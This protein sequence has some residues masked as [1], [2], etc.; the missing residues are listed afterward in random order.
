MAQSRQK[1]SADSLRLHPTKNGSSLAQSYYRRARLAV[2][3]GKLTQ[4]IP[5]YRQT[6]KQD[7]QHLIAHQELGNVF[8]KL[9]QWQQAISC[10]HQALEIDPS[11]SLIHHNLGE[12]YTQLEQRD[13]AVSAYQQ[14]IKL[15]PDSHWS[16][17]NLGDIFLKQEQ[18][19]KAIVA[20]K[21]AIQLNPDFS[22]SHHNLGKA[23]LMLQQ[24]EEAVT[25]CQKAIELNSDSCWSYYNLAE[26][27]L[28]LQKWDE[29]VVAYRQALQLQPDL[30]QATDRLNYALHQRV[31]SKLELAKYHY[32]KAIEQDPDNIELYHKALELQPMSPELY[33]GLGKAWQN[34]GEFQE[35]IA[36]YEKAIVFNPN[37]AEVYGRLAEVLTRVGQETEALEARFKGLTLEPSFATP[38]EHL[39]L[40]DQ[41]RE[42]GKLEQAEICYQRVLKFNPDLIEAYRRLGQLL[43]QSQQWDKAIDWYQQ[44]IKRFP[45]NAECYQGL[46]EVWAKQGEWEKAIEFFEKAIE[47]QPDCWQAYHDCGDALLNLERWQEAVDC[48]QRSIQLNPD[49]VWSYWNLGRVYSK[50]GNWEKVWD[51]CQR[52][53]E[54]DS[55]FLDA[56]LV[57]DGNNISEELKQ[58]I[59]A[60]RRGEKNQQKSLEIEQNGG[61]ILKYNEDNYIEKSLTLNGNNTT[62]KSMDL[63]STEMIATNSSKPGEV[64]VETPET[65]LEQGDAFRKEGK[66]EEARERYQKVIELEPENWLAHHHKGDCL[67]EQQQWEK[68]IEVYQRVITLNPKFCWSYYNLGRALQKLNRLEKAITVIQKAVEVNSD[69]AFGYASWGDILVQQQKWDE[70]ITIYQKALEKNS[71]FLQV[72]EQSADSFFEW[73]KYVILAQKEL[74][75]GEEEEAIKLYKQAVSLNPDKAWVYIKLGD[76]CKKDHQNEAIDNY[77]KAKLIEPNNVWSYINLADIFNRQ[78]RFKE[79]IANYKEGK[80]RAKNEVETKLLQK[81]KDKIDENYNELGIVKQSNRETIFTDKTLNKESESEKLYKKLQGEMLEFH[82]FSPSDLPENL[83]YTAY[84][85]KYLGMTTDNCLSI[86]ERVGV[87]EDLTTKIK[88]IVKSEI[89]WVDYYLAINNTKKKK[90]SDIQI[91]IEYIIYGSLENTHPLFDAYYYIHQIPSLAQET[92]IN[93]LIHFLEIGWNQG[94]SPHPLF[95]TSYYLEQRPDVRKAGINP[96]EHF[97]KFGANER[98]KNPHPLFDILYYLNDNPDINASGMNPLQHFI[99][100]GIKEERNPHPLFNTSYYLQNNPSVKE[101]GKNPINHFMKTGGFDSRDPHPLFSITNYIDYLTLVNQPLASTENPFIN[102]L[103]HSED[104][105]RFACF[106]WKSPNYS[107]LSQEGHYDILVFSHDGSRT[108]APRVLLAFLQQIRESQV[109]NNLKDINIWIV[110]VRDGEL[111]ADFEKCGLTLVLSELDE[112]TKTYNENLQELLESFKR[113]TCNPLVLVNTSA[114]SNVSKVCYE[115]NLPVVSW[116][117]ELPVTIES[118]CGGLDSFQYILLSS[119][120]IIS[121]SDFVASSLVTYSKQED[122]ADKFITIYASPPSLDSKESVQ[123]SE[124]YRNTIRAEFD[125]PDNAFIVMGC[126]TVQERKGCDFFAQVAYQVVKTNKLTDVYFIWVGAKIQPEFSVWLDDDILKADLEENVIFAG[127]RTNPL[128]YMRG[129][130]VFLLT[131]REDPFPLVNMEAMYCKL[132]VI[133]FFGNGGASEVFE[134]NRG[135]AVPYLDTTEMAKAVIRLKNDKQ[136]RQEIGLTAQDCIENKL[137]WQNFVDNFITLIKKDYG[138]QTKKEFK[139]TVVV[140]NYNYEK[141]IFE[142]LETIINQTVKPDE[143]IFLDDKST[144]NSPEIAIKYFDKVNIPNK[145]LINQEN[146]GSPFKQWVKGIREATG[147]LIWIAESDDSCNIDLVRRLKQQFYDPDVVLAYSQSA[148]IGEEGQK[149]DE[150]YLAYTNELDDKKWKIHYRNKGISEIQ[151]A[152]CLK[153]TIP[154]ASAV[155]FRK[156]ALTEECLSHIQKFRFIGDWLLY[157][158]VA[159]AGKVAFVADTLNYHRRHSKTVTAQVEKEDSHAQEVL[160]LKQH[161]LS[162]DF[163]SANA[164]TESLARTIDDFYDLNKRHQLNRNAFVGYQPFEKSIQE[165]RSNFQQRFFKPTSSSLSILIII[166]D[167]NF[168]GGQIAAIRLANELAKKYRVFLCNARPWNYSNDI[169]D[170]I[171]DRVIS[172]EGDLRDK[173]WSGYP[174]RRLEILRSLVQFHQ[175]DVIFSHIWWGDRLAYE[176]NQELKL[177]WF[178]RMHGCY[179]NMMESLEIDDHF[180]K[181]I[182]PMMKF[183]TGI[184]YSTQKN[185][186]VFEELNI[187][188]P[189]RIT[190]LFNGFD[191]STIDFSAPEASLITRGDGDFIFCLCSRAIPDKGWEEAISAIINI[192]ELP[193]EKR[194]YKTARLFLIGD[195]DYAQEL[196][197]KYASYGEITFL[198]QQKKPA[199]FYSRCDVGLLPSRF[200]S[201]SVPSTVIEYLA[202]DLPVVAT[203]IGSVPEMIVADGKEAGFLVPL[204][205]DW[206]FKTEILQEFMLRY[207]NDGTIYSEHKENTRTVFDKLFDIKYLGNEYIKFLTAQVK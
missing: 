95:D 192:N 67:F 120:R 136:L 12:A 93:P 35:A 162:H 70:A 65:Y 167:A 190:Q 96:L 142:R 52:I 16:H 21:R 174:Q 24:W 29:A 109:Q 102:F 112:W 41:L 161:I 69:F 131:S 115:Y 98:K 195:S 188:P 200:K 23:C 100:F 185:L 179:E 74:E 119:K 30:P 186:R 44:G 133:S 55:S 76:L 148:P 135:V 33:M 14:A 155:M 203:A 27:L 37:W 5:H 9:E 166:G 156:S 111:R 15:K 194:S 60:Y 169:I 187:V 22:W 170:L 39:A 159:K 152:L 193:Q 86:S 84:R 1:S 129:S 36:A 6:L 13:E 181:Y 207:M 138:Y 40:G 77:E 106:P 134:N 147:D 83:D 163:I 11:F 87:L 99:E 201:E 51:C 118:Y 53:D 178:I 42:V 122:Q 182:E 146:T 31:K 151:N 78:K 104:S 81:I 176:I 199:N 20:Y 54:I 48:Y 90:K 165:I 89:F 116:I 46:G 177:P 117:H 8:L 97:I 130:D 171:D 125:L 150:N 91:I 157:F 164:I 113:F 132:P 34:Q 143:I 114:I 107:I 153:N 73:L 26:A 25:A 175:I 123:K 137:T 101:E 57:D 7:P 140:P 32:G 139:V 108:G 205:S 47:L 59:A 158:Y 145:I 56:C 202:C 126:G 71:E 204:S 110:L 45:E 10:Y 144:D 141:F 149:F 154:N 50:L 2:Q 4:A 82:G 18:W 38:E 66:W 19:I 58:A 173:P 121:V 206:Q 124:F 80:E 198:G 105:S 62:L 64:Q 94:R 127:S 28:H 49:F 72:K 68:A 180:M 88:L 103:Q 85:K 184:A 183:T 17:N 160:E 3:Q 196:Q 168:G 189:Q 61:Q 92:R 63:K 191:R 172:I 79:A 128:D 75:A 43:T 197:K